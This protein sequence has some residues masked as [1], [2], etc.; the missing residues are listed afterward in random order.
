MVTIS[1]WGTANILTILGF[2]LR[3]SDRPNFCEIAWR[4]QEKSKPMSSLPAPCDA[5]MSQHKFWRQPWD[6]QF[7]WIKNWKSGASSD[8]SL[9]PE[10]FSARWQQVPEPQRPFFRWVANGETWLEFAVRIQQALNRLFQEHEGKTI[11]LVSHGGVIQASFLYFFG[12]SA[13][14]T[15][16]VSMENTSITQWVKPEN[17]QKWVLKRFNDHAHL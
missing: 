11:V 14:N 6:S 5:L 16:S 13:T 1:I 15:P 4:G 9:S 7:F 2:H 10:E 12:L 17:A 3:E 8:G